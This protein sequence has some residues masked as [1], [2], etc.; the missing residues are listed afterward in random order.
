LDK[1]M[2]RFALVLGALSAAGPLA[3]DMYLPALPSIARDLHASQSHAEMSL[4]SFFLG[5][6]LGSPSMVP[7]PTASAGAARS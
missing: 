2:A 4:M 5:L 1:Q 3:I 7:C 6:T